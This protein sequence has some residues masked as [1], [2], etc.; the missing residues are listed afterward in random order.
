MRAHHYLGIDIGS[1]SIGLVLIDERKTILHHEY[2]FHY[3][4]IASLLAERLAALDLAHV[5]QVGHNHR[6]GDFFAGAAGV[7]SINDQLACI[8]GILYQHPRTGSAFAIGGE[9]FGLILFDENFKYRKYIS[10]SSCAAG[11][12][13]FLD[14]QA[15]R[16]GLPGSAELSRL[17]DSFEGQPP[18]IA[19]R[20]AVFAKTDLIHCQQQGYP[21]E[22]ISAGLCQ[23]L[24]HNIYDTLSKGVV[25]QEPLVA[26][27][28][29]SK[30][31][32]VMHYLSELTGLPILIPEYSALSG[33]IGCAVIAHSRSH[34]GTSQALAAP[35]SLDSLLKKQTQEKHYFYGPL[36]PASAERP[37]HPD[38]TGQRHYVSQD[39]EVDAYEPLINNKDKPGI[40]S[41]YLGIDIG[42]T[43]TKAVVMDA[44]HPGDKIYFG[45]Y[46]RTAGQPIQA[47]QSL[48]SVLDEIQAQQGIQF[49]FLGVGTTGSGRNFIQKVLNADLAIDEITAHARAAYA[50]NPE[51][52]TIIEIGGQDSKFTVLKNG[53]VV[54]SVMNFV[55]A[56]GTGSFI[57]EQA[58]RLAVPL[59][60]YA[61]RASGVPS[62]LTSDR[63]TVFMER[64]LNHYLSQ[65]YAREELLA[66]ALH[67]VVD[68]YLSKVAPPNKIGKVICF[69]GATAKNEALVAV[70]EE[71]LQKPIFVSKYCHLTGA[72]G[73]CLLLREKGV[74]ET[75]FRGIEFYKQSPKVTEEVCE[76][77][78]NHCKLKRVY[79]LQAGDE[80]A[81]SILWGFL[82]GRDE[83]DHK[84]KSS[85]HS[86]F[87][88]L[89]SR[90]KIFNPVNTLDEFAAA[91]LDAAA[92]AP[93]ST[94]PRFRRIPL[95]V[96]TLDLG[97]LR[98]NLDLSVLS[99]RHKLF[100]F[101]QADFT[102][103]VG[104]LSLTIG[105]PNTLYNLELVPFWKF[106]F[107]KLGYRVY[108]A[109]AR[110]ALMEKG[111][112]IA[113]AEFCTPI[114]YW[115]GHVADLSAHAD[116]LFLPQMFREGE[117]KDARFYCYYSNYAVALVRNN[118]RLNIENRCITPVISFSSPAIDNVQQIYASLPQELK[119]L[120]TPG[121][122][123]EAY[124]QALRWFQERKDML[125][126]VF[127]I[128]RSDDEQDATTGVSVVLVGRPYLIFDPV[129]NKNIPDKFNQLGVKTFSQDMLPQTGDADLAA[130]LVDWTH[131]E[132]GAQILKVVE[133]IGKTP[134]LYPVYLS[135]F[136]CSPDSFVIN[137]FKEVMDAYQ[138]PY[139][140]LQIDEHGSD[141]GYGTR[142]ESAVET[143]R[144]HFQRS[145]PLPV[146][147]LPAAE[148][149][150]SFKQKTILIPNYDPLCSD[151]MSAAFQHAGFQARIIEETPTTVLASLRV[152]DGQCLPISSIVQG[153]IETI[154]K[155]DLDPAQSAL[156]LN[157]M[158]QVPCNLP[159]Y[160][161][162]ARKLLN[163]RGEGFEKVQVFAT[164]LNMTGLPLEL[165][166]DIYGTFLLGG[167]LRKIGCKL[168]PYE[169][170]QGQTDALI[171]SA[172]ARLHQCIADGE[173]KDVAFAEI[174]ANFA[175]MPLHEGL[176]AA[177][178]PK[179]AIIGDLYVQDN[180]V[181]NQQLTADLE[182]YGAEVITVPVNYAFRLM[183]EKDRIAYSKDRRYLSLLGQKILFEVAEKYENHFYQLARGILNEEL[184]TFD[185]TII[186]HLKKYNLSLKHQGETAQNVLKILSLLKH[187]PDIRLF[188]H[189]NPIFCCPGLVSESIFKT[190]EEDIG[191]PIVSIVYDGTTTEKN[192]LLA[193]T[194]H[195][196]L[197][198]SKSR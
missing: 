12:G 142:V 44:T 90:R 101:R 15:E 120:Q 116:Y 133:T 41:A 139:L 53:H 108:S 40:V 105:I 168:R 98:E 164:E 49:D 178:R 107:T 66:A 26:A 18:K 138:K 4:N 25:L 181:F 146:N 122:I 184:P 58:R 169:I 156:F 31:R 63:C 51:V 71:K 54:F 46:T 17:A 149:P 123:R 19:T 32:R 93:A 34:D 77:C 180:D 150:V 148:A 162:M 95:S 118:R 52:D 83:N 154:Q 35:L 60:E 194:M 173:S 144:N 189:V 79:A 81:D 59:N 99:M 14:Q 78:Q 84:R 125:S 24:A 48:L 166:Y 36:T 16:L 127:R 172:L 119:L 130:N 126:H 6:S 143:F 10:N 112:E 9:T 89:S 165:I 92:P 159:Q 22:A 191:I 1:V 176:R 8:E 56:A 197:Q 42:S 167:L 103:K 61:Q 20:C 86:G 182:S 109:P 82:C 131:W 121:Q 70:L 196:I 74:T 38:F 50:L 23:G 111:K 27:G 117:N 155:N 157:A 11:T 75:H 106:F 67:S 96:P 175:D 88:L 57:E 128:I 129:L 163:Q 97:K 134:G 136:K 87:D 147:V 28:G 43:S 55:C 104:R 37:V 68:N 5:A 193:P 73:V 64:D 115:H 100:T 65:G 183:A 160:P 7:T 94:R 113:G 124:T 85:N 110:E 177:G 45:L 13:A 69:Q 187:Y 80:Q 39:V 192:G 179:V 174:V 62:P 132:Y 153:A 198:S 185:D 158:A 151:L 114:A 102:E 137:Q 186:E 195:Y 171:A 76:L 141:V 170:N 140:I 145:N 33:A 161:L 152:N 2:L 72:L 190:L 29:V 188:V 47:T 135:A 30:N 21:L 3:G 91:S